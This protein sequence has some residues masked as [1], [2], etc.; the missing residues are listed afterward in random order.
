MSFGLESKLEIFGSNRRVFVRRSV[1]ERM[2]S[3]C[4]SHRKARR[5]WCD[6]ALLVTLSDFN[7]FLKNQGT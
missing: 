1:D 5:R 4:I 6:G 7:K 3:A 2:I